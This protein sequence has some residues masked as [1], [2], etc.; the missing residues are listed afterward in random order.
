MI[1]KTWRSL[2][3]NK[4]DLSMEHQIF[5][6]FSIFLFLALAIFLLTS[7]ILEQ[8]NSAYVALLAIIVQSI[9]FYII[10]YYNKI[11][12][13]ILLFGAYSNILLVANY[14]FNSGISGPSI[15]A[16]LISLFIMLSICK[17]EHMFLFF[18]INIIIVC[19]ISTAEY[20]FPTLIQNFYSTKSQLFADNM[21]TYTICVIFMYLGSVFI[22]DNYIK[23]KTERLQKTISLENLNKSKDK[24]LSIISHD[25]RSP[26]AAI[27]Q[28]LELVNQIDLEKEDR[29]FIE[30]SLLKTTIN[31]QELLNNLLQWSKSQLDGNEVDIKPINLKNELSKTIESVSLLAYHKNIHL[32]SILKDNIIILADA[33]MLQMVV[34]NLLHN[35]I[36]FTNSNG[37]VEIVASQLNDKSL[38][39]IKDTGVG[40]DESAQEKVFNL[41]IESTYGTDNENGAGLGL[42]LCKEYTERQGGEIWFSSKKG[43]GTVFYVS[44]PLH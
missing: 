23:E 10:E 30:N 18:G 44:L 41:K 32:K 27:Q 28:Y 20:N 12:L 6:S 5:Y 36:K 40:M 2:L 4:M 17:R 25:L 9:V 11:D 37:V 14:F 42:V 13:A 16:F 7:L 19:I 24:L 15:I 35:A 43:E 1:L 31:T 39:T 8:Y 34:R 29:K 26:L 33:N 22:R 38:I 21:S 3:K